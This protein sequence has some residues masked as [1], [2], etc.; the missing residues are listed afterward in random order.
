MEERFSVTEEGARAAARLV[1]VI[2]Y[3]SVRSCIFICIVI[4]Y[5]AVDATPAAT[6]GAGA[7]AFRKGHGLLYSDL[8]L[9]I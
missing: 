2:V 1:N 9:Y 5:I 3:W 4:L 8:K 7:P 6:G